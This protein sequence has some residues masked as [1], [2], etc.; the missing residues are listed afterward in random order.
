[1][2][3]SVNVIVGV[4]AL[5]IVLNVCAVESRRKAISL[6]DSPDLRSSASELRIAALPKPHVSAISS[7]FPLPKGC[8]RHLLT[9]DSI[10][11]KICFAKTSNIDSVIKKFWPYNSFS[12]RSSFAMSAHSFHAHNVLR[13]RFLYFSVLDDQMSA[14]AKKG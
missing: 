13:T 7:G 8:N 14:T 2:D 12:S 1:M 11:L 3:S 4:Y 10:L 5:I 6:S 9:C